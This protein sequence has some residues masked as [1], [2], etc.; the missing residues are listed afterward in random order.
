MSEIDIKAWKCDRPGCGHI[1]IGYPKPEKCAKCKCRNW[2]Q[3]NAEPVLNSDGDQ[4][5][6]TEAS[7]PTPEQFGKACDVLDAVLIE[8]NRPP[9][10]GSTSRPTAGQVAA[11]IPKVTTADK[12]ERPPR[13]P[14]GLCPH[15]AD[16]K[17]C[18]MLT[19]EAARRQ[20]AKTAK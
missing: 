1:W 20:T 5:P 10:T 18:R 15:D 14:S 17:F 9:R 16:P 11:S 19:C 7:E 4:R 3:P 12:L 6:Q 2:D 13:R 8:T